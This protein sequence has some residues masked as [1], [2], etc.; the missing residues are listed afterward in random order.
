M[1]IRGNVCWY[2]GHCYLAT[3]PEVG[4]RD[5]D[6]VLQIFLK[7]KAFEFRVLWFLKKAL[8]S[9]EEPD[10]S[11]SMVNSKA[12]LHLLY[13][14]AHYACNISPKRGSALNTRNDFIRS[15]LNV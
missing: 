12:R 10:I 14:R 9:R 7:W 5:Q 1:L 4:F 11:L 3:R 2:I 15:I 6:F 13:T 8:P